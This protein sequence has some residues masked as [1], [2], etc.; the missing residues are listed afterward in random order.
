MKPYLADNR[1]SLDAKGMMSLVCN[2]QTK[3]SVGNTYLTDKA[4]SLRAKGLLAILLDISNEEVSA[5]ILKKYC[6][7][8]IRDVVKGLNELESLNYIT[9]A[10]SNIR[11]LGA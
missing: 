6:S 10:N 4:L 9:L 1:L 3:Q 5:S 7:D 11:V 8:S 2:F